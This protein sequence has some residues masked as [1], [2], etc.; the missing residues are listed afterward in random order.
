MFWIIFTLLGISLLGLI[1]SLGAVTLLDLFG[2]WGIHSAKWRERVKKNQQ[3]FRFSIWSGII[4]HVLSTLI[5]FQLSNDQ[6]ILFLELFIFASII[7]TTSW[8]SFFVKPRIKERER[9]GLKSPTIPPLWIKY[10]VV[11]FVLTFLAWWLIGYLTLLD[12]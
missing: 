4:I 1:I 7:I 9:R 12:L 10:T 5:L 6:I 3:L 2:F 11:S 8:V